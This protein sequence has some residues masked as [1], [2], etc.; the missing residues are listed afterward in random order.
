MPQYEDPAW[1][2]AHPTWWLLTPEQ[3]YRV[4]LV[5]ACHTTS[6]AIV[7]NMENTVEMRN[8]ILKLVRELSDFDASVEVKPEDRLVTFSTCTYENTDGRYVLV[9]VLR[10][11]ANP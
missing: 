4:D 10:E 7:Y 5:A 2:E 1:Y 9:G 3:N 11:A 6:D 8:R